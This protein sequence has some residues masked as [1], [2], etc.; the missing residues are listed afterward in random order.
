MMELN[1]IQ[2]LAIWALPMIFAITVHEVA[3]GWVAFKFGDQTARLA[4][5][6]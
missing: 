6:Y 2:K 1:A 3:H 5:I 4:G